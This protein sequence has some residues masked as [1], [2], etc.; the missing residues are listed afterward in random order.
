MAAGG[1]RGEIRGRYKRKLG[2]LGEKDDGETDEWP[3]MAD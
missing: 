2:G 3:N 1:T